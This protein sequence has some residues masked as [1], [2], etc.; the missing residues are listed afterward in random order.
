MHAGAGRRSGGGT[1][2]ARPFHID[3][4]VFSCRCRAAVEG[5]WGVVR[6]RWAALHPLNAAR[7]HEALA[8]LQPLAEIHVR[9]PQPA[10]EPSLFG[11]YT[12]TLC[13]KACYF[14]CSCYMKVGSWRRVQHVSRHTGIMV[15]ARSMPEAHYADERL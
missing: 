4:W 3:S 6:E 7:R 15:E 14:Q 11:A 8:L 10:P 5:A 12:G 13:Q 9:A 1:D 2:V